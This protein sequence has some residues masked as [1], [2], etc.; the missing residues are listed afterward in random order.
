MKPNL[1][2]DL[3]GC[4]S[5]FPKLHFWNEAQTKMK[6]ITAALALALAFATTLHAQDLSPELVPLITKHKADL[7][8]LDE[9]KAAATARVVQ[10][11]VAALDA[12]EAKAT[13]AGNLKATAAIAQESNDAKSGSL[14][15]AVPAELPK[16]LHPAR[17]SCLDGIA[18]ITPDLAAANDRVRADYLRALATLQ[19]RAGGNAAL[20]AQIA[21]EKGRALSEITPTAPA[22]ILTS[23]VWTLGYE[24][25]EFAPSGKLIQRQPSP[26]AW[27]GKAW[28]LSAN[29][30]TVECVFGNGKTGAYLFENGRLFHWDKTLG[31]FKR[32]PL[33]Q[34]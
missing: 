11:Y 7:A 30:K 1:T 3:A 5:A 22:A 34:P 24:T 28:K 31:E 15:D 23:Y 17:K 32:E 14:R 20:T 29:R 19:A 25:W 9:Q 27:S 12:A 18:R 2:D 16:S 8:T 21:E 13:S 6:T 26:P 33:R 10:V 4:T